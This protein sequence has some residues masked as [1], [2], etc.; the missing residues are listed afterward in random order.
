MD[1]LIDVALETIGSIDPWLRTLI[2]GLAI[3]LETSVLL[4]LVVPGDTIVIIAALAVE[5]WPWWLALIGATVVGALC[6]ETIGFAIGRWLGP[7][8]DRWLARRW[9]RASERWRRTE[10]YLS[11]RG[12]IAI[13]LSRFLPVAHS[14]V[15]LIVGG[16]GMPYRRFLAWTLPACVLWA[17]AYATAGWLAGGTYRELADEL[18][19]AGFVLVGAVV[20]FLL[21]VWLVK[22]LVS[23]GEARHMED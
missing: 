13:F 8:I 4:G 6:G 16:A 21:L 5:E 2:A 12:G 19:G 9:P 3:L 23:R 10:R 18:H 15:P 14:L 20:A 1:D 22:H 17:S 7:S 11:R